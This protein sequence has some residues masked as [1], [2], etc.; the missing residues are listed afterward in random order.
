MQ[1]NSIKH[2]GFEEVVHCQDRASGLNAFIAVHSTRLGP[3]L[4]G[5]RMYP[6]PSEKE[7]LADALRLARAMSYKSAAAGLKLGGGKAVILGD[8]LTQ[9][10]PA[11]L[12][13]M[14]KFVDHLQGRYISAKDA[15][16]NTQDLVAISEVTKHVTGLPS[17]MGGSGDP[18][19]WTA[20]GIYEGIKA[21][22]REKFGKEDLKGL[23]TAIQGVGHVGLA[24]AELLAAGGSS[25]LI[26]DTHSQAMEKAKKTLKAEAVLPEAIFSAGAEIFSPCALGGVVNDQTLS[27]FQFSIIAG[28]ANNQLADEMRHDK[29]LKEKGILYA[30]DYIL[31]AGGVIN[32]YVQ[33]ILK[34]KD[35]IPWIRKIR[36]TLL[37]V[38]KLA[39][40]RNI[41][42]AQAANQMTEEI[43]LG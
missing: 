10:T 28:G 35:P 42:T 27:Q 29:L 37:E 16:I 38:F 26:T 3:S 20:Q 1:I 9:K 15:G 2:E 36:A 33:D 39:G 31:N 11:L 12:K 21:C 43:L 5:I 18:S 7:A 17:E 30:P 25:L 19:P 13:A 34:E 32:I 14:G 23:R 8:P 41:G 4:G 22:A 6:Y 24:L 40:R